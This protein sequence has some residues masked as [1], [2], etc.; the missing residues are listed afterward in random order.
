MTEPESQPESASGSA[1][2]QAVEKGSR[3]RV[4]KVIARAGIV[5]RRE[6]EE[7]IAQGRVSVNG[8]V[9]SE[10]GTTVSLE[11]TVSIDGIPLPAKERT[12]LW[13][14]HK[15]AGVVTTTS[16]PEGRT[17][18]FEVL[19][20]GLPRVV[21]VGR[22]D[23]NTE[24]LLLLT[25]DGG[26]A[27]VLE[28][29]ETGWLRRYRVRAYGTI[30]HGALEAL[31]AGI[32]I[33]GFKF[34]PI[35][36]KVDREQGDNVWLTLGLREGKNR[37]V[38]RVL[39]YI[40]LR[41]NRL[42]R[43]SFGP[44]SLGELKE[45]AFE[46]VRTRYLKDQLGP[47]LIQE[48]AADFDAPLIH[49]RDGAPPEDGSVQMAKKVAEKSHKRVG[50]TTD[51]KGKRV[52]VERS[53]APHEVEDQDS[54]RN[55]RPPRR[56][57]GDRPQRSFGDRPDRE[58]RE[59]RP[60]R[61]FDGDR[62]QRSFGDRPNRE[63][64]EGRPPR[65]FDGDRPQR[66]FGDRPDR[67]GR[68]S[69]PPRRFDG[70]R[71]QRSFGDRPNREGDD[72]GPRR[73]VG[74]GS[75]GFRNNYRSEKPR[76][77]FEQERSGGESRPPRRFDGDR[78]QRSFGDRPDREGRDS[79]PPRRFDGDR[80]QRSFGDRPNR[81]GG[82]GRPPRRFDGDRPQRSFG[83]R[84]NNREGGEGRPPRR[85]DGDRPQRSFGDRPNREGRDSRPPRRFDGDRPQRSFGDRPD[86]EGRDSRPPRHFDGDRPQRS[87][88][89]RPNNRDGGGRPDKGGRPPFKRD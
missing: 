72:R 8:A 46:E 48:A 47:R 32:E 27:R 80:P 37:E 44:F 4:A 42:I 16:D 31:E 20:E 43:T 63:G 23:I 15:T 50:T 67:E 77:R 7:L 21:T 79:R 29:P 62:P 12:R 14:Y 83:D 10:P 1:P 81:E 78:P 6:A 84:P 18:V 5:S 51:R 87:F 70:D 74:E 9:I 2:E 41:V 24:G 66:S 60:P 13:L 85:F 34:E 36:V 89:D 61:R 26:L 57:D 30:S 25:N 75:E 58:G 19:P 71:P 69:R 33:D 45:G 59:G 68:D 22:L 55:S 35:T 86:R 39:D 88:G 28:L 40:G 54:R 64:G 53:V 65:R 17:T 73:F 52:V 11:D 76:S 3:A 38:K 82:E 49:Q 56:F